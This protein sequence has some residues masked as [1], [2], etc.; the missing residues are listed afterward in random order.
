M[1]FII[2]AFLF[3]SMNGLLKIHSCTFIQRSMKH[4][5]LQIQG[6][7]F[8]KILKS[9]IQKTTQRL[10]CAPVITTNYCTPINIIYIYIYNDIS[11]RLRVQNCYISFCQY[12]FRAG[13]LR[14]TSWLNF[15]SGSIVLHIFLIRAID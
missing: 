13:T 15:C 5:P 6:T 2:I 8:N 10:Q 9:C 11:C 7:K 1:V 12:L 4:L 3:Y 14:D